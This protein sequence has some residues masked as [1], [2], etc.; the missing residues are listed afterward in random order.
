MLSEVKIKKNAAKFYNTGEKYNCLTPELIDALGVGIVDAPA[1]TRTDLHNAFPGGLVDH[2]LRVTKYCV[3]LNEILPEQ[4]Q[5]SMESLIKVAML[6]Q[7][8]KVNLYV[9]NESSWHLERGI[10]YDFNKDVKTSMK[11]GDRSIYLAMSNGI[12]LTE[13]EYVAILNFDRED[14]LQ[15]KYHNSDLGDLLKSANILAIN[16]EKFTQK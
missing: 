15:A 7:L 8:G 12:K 14:D 16:E 6:F 3:S 13:D 5:H 10:M 4:Q 9:K 1:S 2:I 11:V